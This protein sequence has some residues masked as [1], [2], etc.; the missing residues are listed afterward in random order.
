MSCEACH[1]AAQKWLS[2]HYTEEW[3][4]KTPSEKSL[5]GMIDTKNV[6]VRAEVCARCHVGE[7]DMDVNHDLIAAGHPR[8]SFEL[9]LYTAR[10][11][12]HWNPRDERARY[13]DFEARAWLVGQAVSAQTALEL[14][15]DRAE[16]AGQ[17]KKP[18]PEFAEYAC[19]ACHHDLK[20]PSPRQ[21]LGYRGRVPGAAHHLGIV[22]VR[23]DDEEVVR[24]HAA[25]L[26]EKQRQAAEEERGELF[27]E[28]EVQR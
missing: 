20:E 26:L 15:A 14:L 11:P 6:R 22:L 18:W 4:R 19:F 10:M 1:G 24:G 7:G 13:P 2:T 12:K 9:G 28:R 27:L 5:E 25:T 23:H 21:Q 17:R 16:Q 3:R 8:L